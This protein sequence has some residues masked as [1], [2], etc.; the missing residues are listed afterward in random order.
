MNKTMRIEAFLLLH[1]TYSQ[2]RLDQESQR[3]AQKQTLEPC[4]EQI[5]P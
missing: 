4:H 3:T 5:I 1:H 2:G